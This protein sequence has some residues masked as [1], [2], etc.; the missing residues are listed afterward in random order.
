MMEEHGF[1]SGKTVVIPLAF[2]DKLLKCYY[3]GG[4]RENEKDVQQVFESPAT[5]VLTT[6]PTPGLEMATGYPAGFKPKGVALRKLEAKHGAG[7]DQAT[8]EQTSPSEN[9]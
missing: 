5:E 7:H 4:P 6:E 2:F 9:N 8:E 3:G 1:D